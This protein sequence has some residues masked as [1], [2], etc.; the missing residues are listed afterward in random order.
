M[1]FTRTTFALAIASLILIT[2][3]TTFAAPKHVTILHFNDLHGHLEP[4]NV[5]G[6]SVGGAARITTIVRNIEA[7]NSARSGETLVLFGGDALTGTLISS[8]FKGA[9]EFDFLNMLGVD[10]FVIGNHEFDNGIPKLQ[11]LIEQAKFPIISANTYW[12]D[13]GNRLTSPSTLIHGDKID[14]GIIGLTTETTSTSANPAKVKDLKF[15]SSIREAKTEIRAL[16]NKTPFIIAL[17]HLGVRGDIRLAKKTKDLSAII[18]GHDHV[19]TNEYCRTVHEIPICQTPA[20]GRYVGRLDFDVDGTNIKYLGSKLIPI[21]E[22]I[23][24][25]RK[26][27]QLIAGYSKRLA[28]KFNKVVGR[29]EIDLYTSRSGRTKLGTFVAESVKWKM[30]TEIALIN[31]GSVRAPIKR[32]PIR[33]KD[34]MAVQPFDNRLVCFNAKGRDIKEALDHGIKRGGGAFPQTAGISFDVAGK[35]AKNILINNSPIDINRT[36]TVASS[37]F[38]LTGGDGYSLFK[39]L[40]GQKYSDINPADALADYIRLKRVIKP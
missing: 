32:G 15:I 39:D 5:D 2:S 11:Q 3:P 35:R 24:E 13:S 12:K 22:N 33:L 27:K 18:G 8:Q 28:K 26:T 23:R 20:N 30:G 36:Y 40:P 7:E 1:K 16:K 37:D 38:L 17:T 4:T 31:S 25:D 14:I 21:T 19:S 10:A 34:V 6:K 9:A 29:S